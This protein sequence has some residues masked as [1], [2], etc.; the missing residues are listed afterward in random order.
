M[1]T[2]DVD[3]VMPA[4]T[5]DP[6][7]QSKDSIKTGRQPRLTSQLAESYLVNERGFSLTNASYLVA[8]LRATKK[9]ISVD[10]L[11]SIFTSDA[12]TKLANV[13]KNAV[14]ALLAGQGKSRLSYIP[15]TSLS[16]PLVTFNARMKRSHPP[17]HS[18]RT[19]CRGT[20]FFSI[21][22]EFAEIVQGNSKLADLA[23]QAENILNQI[24]SEEYVPPP[25][26]NDEYSPPPHT[27]PVKSQSQAPQSS[28]SRPVFQHPDTMEDLFTAFN[29]DNK[30]F[31]HN[32]LIFY[33]FLTL[34]EA[35]AL[36]EYWAAANVHIEYK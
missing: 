28:P 14:T 20:A 2:I 21:H 27:S 4:R 9:S 18:R 25:A 29:N 17:R 15:S 32:T 23:T 5:E 16:V 24:D 1:P 11:R 31:L 12:A 35:D 30:E 36:I 6:R 33:Y 3:K 22:R 13:K 10:A 7:L 19:L 34:K 26:R 8:Y